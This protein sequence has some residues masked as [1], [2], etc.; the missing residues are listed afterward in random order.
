MIL[1]ATAIDPA[2]EHYFEVL[3][4]KPLQQVMEEIRI[5]GTPAYFPVHTVTAAQASR[6]PEAEEA[7]LGVVRKEFEPAWASVIDRRTTS[8]K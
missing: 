8:L 4:G 2:Q 6:G 3:W 5:I 1:R 7:F